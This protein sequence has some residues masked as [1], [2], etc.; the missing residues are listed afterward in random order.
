MCTITHKVTGGKSVA[1]DFKLTILAGSVNPVVT[2][3]P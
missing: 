3:D 1:R 2:V